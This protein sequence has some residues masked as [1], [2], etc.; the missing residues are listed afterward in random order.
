[1]N[2]GGRKFFWTVCSSLPECTASQPRVICINLITVNLWASSTLLVGYTA[3][4]TLQYVFPILP[5]NL[6]MAEVWQCDIAEWGEINECVICL[7][8]EI[9]LNISRPS[10]PYNHTLWWWNYSSGNVLELRVTNCFSSA[11]FHLNK[12]AIDARRSVWWLYWWR[13]VRDR[14]L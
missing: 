7:W 5:Q 4:S 8:N 14:I 6:E 9:C 2:V 11:L 1:M 10:E 12:R 13:S 3:F